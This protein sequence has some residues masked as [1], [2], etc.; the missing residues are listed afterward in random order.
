MTKD[1][2]CGMPVDEKNALSS[3]VYKGAFYAFC[4]KDCKDKFDLTPDRYA[5]S[6][7]HAS[8][9]GYEAHKST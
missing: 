4:C 2:V 7:G 1:P 3:S 9:A 6:Q 8:R 5:V